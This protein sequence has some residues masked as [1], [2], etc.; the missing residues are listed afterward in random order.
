MRVIVHHAQHPGALA[1]ND[2]APEA[3]AVVESCVCLLSTLTWNDDSVISQL[4]ACG[5]LELLVAQLE[6]VSRG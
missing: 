6:C 4:V 3:R 1:E 2:H 5:G